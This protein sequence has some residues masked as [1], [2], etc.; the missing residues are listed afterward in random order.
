MNRPTTASEAE[1]Q[2][3]TV[4]VEVEVDDDAAVAGAVCGRRGQRGGVQG[5]LLAV[6]GLDL[7]GGAVRVGQAGSQQESD[8]KALCVNIRGEK[9]YQ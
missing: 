5:E 9:A 8:V 6:G 7:E 1:H 2:V 4:Q 3:P